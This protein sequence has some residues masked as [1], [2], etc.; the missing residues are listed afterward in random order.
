MSLR[1][2]GLISDQTMREHRAT[3]WVWAGSEKIRH[4]AKMRG[5][6]GY[7]ATCSCG[8]ESH[9]GG[10]TKRY[11]Q[12]VLDDHRWDAQLGIEG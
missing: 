5:A 6:W 4:T 10:G 1:T 7:D 2:L 3:W 8:W 11:I 9:V 12:E